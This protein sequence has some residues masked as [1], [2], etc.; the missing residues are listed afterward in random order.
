MTSIAHPL[1]AAAIK[2][3][4]WSISK[5][6][7]SKRFNSVT[8]PGHTWWASSKRNHSPDNQISSIEEE[9]AW[10]M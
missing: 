4:A 9:V 10:L 6:R 2:A 3:F 1:S 5:H 8:G 7:N